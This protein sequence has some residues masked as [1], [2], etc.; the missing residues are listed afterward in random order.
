[1]S[2]EAVP[3]TTDTLS[4]PHVTVIADTKVDSWFGNCDGLNKKEDITET[5]VCE[6]T[7]KNDLN[8][9]IWK[10]TNNSQGLP[11]ACF[12]GSIAHNCR[13][14]NG[15][16]KNVLAS[17]HIQHGE[18]V[19][20]KDNFGLQTLGLLKV[21]MD[22]D[23][24]GNATSLTDRCKAFCYSDTYCTVWQYGKDGCHIE[25]LPYHKAT[26]TSNTSEWANTM[27]AGETIKHVCPPAKKDEE[28]GLPWPLIICG[29]VAGL[30][31]IAALLYVVLLKPKPKTKKTRDVKL[32]KDPKPAPE[33]A[34]IQYIA[35]PT[36]P[37]MP[38]MYQQPMAY[39]P[40]TQQTIV[41]QPMMQMQQP[42][43]T[44]P[45]TQPMMQGSFAGY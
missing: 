15:P 2:G 43:M 45:M 39:R 32:A 37:P 11:Q 9:T 18:V 40:M 21:D 23:T 24:T 27:V 28:A 1:M 38:M 33:P 29:I 31:G 10:M 35:V 7:C 26:G 22:P 6:S 25:H 17:Q 16:P 3:I 44:Q 42:M 20:V 36:Q 5:A 30:L 19:P 14:G 41:Q 34:T 4:C 13:S 8:C 12:Q